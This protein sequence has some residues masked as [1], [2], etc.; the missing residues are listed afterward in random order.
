[1]QQSIVLNSEKLRSISHASHTAE[2]TITALAMRE[3][4][5]HFS[6]IQ[7]TRN[8]LI[9][10]GE[11][12][13]DADY[14]AFWKGLAAAGVGIIVND[15][16]GNPSRFEWYFSMKKVA[17]A[18]LEGKD[19]T[20]NRV[21]GVESLSAKTLGAKLIPIKKQAKVVQMAKSKKPAVQ[22]VKSAAPKQDRFVYIPLRKDFCLEFTVPSN[23]SKDEIQVIKN[24]LERLSA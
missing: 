9:R 14:M 4:L 13:V 17:Q 15:R 8:T 7:R 19:V 3:R 12:I 23:L 22:L 21:V 16:K 2:V 18:A 10:K 24:A 20:A 5:R 6:D 11:K 1:M